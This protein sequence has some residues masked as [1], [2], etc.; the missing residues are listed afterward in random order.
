[1]V[2][3]ITQAVDTMLCE[4]CPAS[5]HAAIASCLSLRFVGKYLASSFAHS[6]LLRTTMESSPLAMQPSPDTSSSMAS[7][8]DNLSLVLLRLLVLAAT[9]NALVQSHFPNPSVLLSSLSR[10]S[11]LLSVA[12]YLIQKLGLI[13]AVVPGVIPF[14]CK[15]LR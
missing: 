14:I 4:H 12:F 15:V 8:D 2:R 10:P 1:M 9:H 5:P 3:V 6:A 11:F 7:I 13:V